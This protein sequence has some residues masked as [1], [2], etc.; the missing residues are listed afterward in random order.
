MD[1]TIMGKNDEEKIKVTLRIPEQKTRLASFHTLP[2]TF[3]RKYDSK[4]GLHGK[5]TVKT[6]H[7]ALMDSRL[8]EL[9]PTETSFTISGH[10]HYP[11]EMSLSSFNAMTWS[12]ENHIQIDFDRQSECADALELVV[13]SRLF[14]NAQLSSAK[15]SFDQFYQDNKKFQPVFDDD[16]E[17]S[18]VEDETEMHNDRR[19]RLN[20]YLKDEYKPRTAYRHF[21]NAVVKTVGGQVDHKVSAKL[22]ATCDSHMA[23]CRINTELRRSPM[24]HGE[25]SEWSL[26]AESQFLM[27][28]YVREVSELN[29]KETSH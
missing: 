7:T 19:S 17:D 15:P 18:K 28:E 26:K 3:I 27:P 24:F 2:L 14:Q 29:D 21:I 22:E 9:H 8:K 5:T 1:A 11:R 4:L 12:H 16:V 6:V 10:F 25:K 20:T 13:S 23:F